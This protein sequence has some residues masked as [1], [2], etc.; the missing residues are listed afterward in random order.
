[1]EIRSA[2]A[3]WGQGALTAEKNLKADL[4]EDF[5]IMTIGPGG[6]K[7]VRY[8]C[9]SH[10]FG[11]QAGRSGVGAVLGSKNIKAIAVRGTKSLPCPRHRK[12]LRQ[13]VSKPSKR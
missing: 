5:Q 2:A 3:Y 13:R 12:G 4:G 8:A 10:D 11:R 1:V 6:E 7:R 9:M